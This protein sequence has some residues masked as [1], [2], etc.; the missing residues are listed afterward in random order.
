[1][2]LRHWLN[3][4]LGSSL[5]AASSLTANAQPPGMSATGPYGRDNMMPAETYGP[6]PMPGSESG[7]P[8]VY[9]SW[10]EMSAFDHSYSQ[11][12][13]EAGIWSQNT[14]NRMRRYRFSIDYLTGKARTT[15]ALIGNPH[16]Q[17]YIDVL[18]PQL[19]TGTGQ[20]GGQQQQNSP[21]TVYGG[22]PSTVPGVHQSHFELY[23]PL[24]FDGYRKFRTDGTRA[25]WGYDNPD[26]SGLRL[27]FLYNAD[28]HFRYDA[29]DRLPDGK[30]TERATLNHLLQ[31]PED[32][33]D[34]NTLLPRDLSLLGQY[35]APADINRALQNNLFNLNGI[36]LDD[37][38]LQVLSDGTEIGGVTVPYDLAFRVNLRSELYGGQADF[39]MTPVLDWKFLKVRPTAGLRY[40]YLREGFNFYGQD[41]GLAYGGGQAAGGGG[42][43]GTQNLSPDMKIHSTPDGIDNDG[44][45][46][47]DNAGKFESGQAAG[48]GGG[49]QQNTTTFLQFHDQFRYPISS[50]LDNG[51]D[52]HMAG[53]V[54]GMTYDIG[55]E[56]FLLTGASR[57]GLLGNYEQIQMKGDNIAMHTRESNLLLPSPS[58][59]TPN[60]FTDSQIHSHVS[61]MFEQSF[62]AEAPLFRAVPGLRKVHILEKAQ[63]RFG[64]SLM[65]I[66]SVI[67]PSASIHWQG[68]PAAGLFPTIKG[69]QRAT[70]SSHSFN[71]G[72]S[73]QF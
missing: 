30:G 26:D 3:T 54:I 10:P 70:Y 53:G 12:S 24:K 20:G 45:G 1:M 59:A 25:M 18:A 6:P 33:A 72:V 69:G 14:N 21:L 42:G 55:G 52:S 50:Y 31:L 27:S 58:D 15:D 41:S 2:R 9:Q 40:F 38:S 8:S 43:G 62:I 35:I 37:G 63:F 13:N 4:I 11:Q 44:D 28:N 34:P 60:S 22:N 61:P 36:P 17:R 16:A 46:I 23:G 48:G 39:V 73:W 5:L 67:D 51:V 49:G 71:F 32:P 68:N 29:R 47:I 66:G 56:S 57:F 7:P 65:L 64:Y 19:Q